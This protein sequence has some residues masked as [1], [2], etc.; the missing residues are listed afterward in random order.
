[1]APS[2]VTRAVRRRIPG[3]VMGVKLASEPVGDGL[4][5]L[6]DL[7]EVARRLEAEGADYI[8]ASNGGHSGEFTTIPPMGSPPAPNAALAANLKRAVRIP[9]TTSHRIRTPEQAERV[10]AD[11]QADLVAMARALIADPEWAAKAQSGQAQEIRHCVGMM[12]CY[13]RTQAATP[14]WCTAN[15]ASG[16]EREYTIR[17][18]RHRKTYAVVGGGPAGLEAARVLATRGHMV[19][20][21]EQGPRLGGKVIFASAIPGREE[22]MEMVDWLERQVTAL[23]VHV[24]LRREFSPASLEHT[25]FDGVVLAV[26]AEYQRPS[27]VF[28]PEAPHL[29][30]EAAVSLTEGVAGQTALVVDREYKGRGPMLAYKLATQGAHV[31][32]L[33]EGQPVAPDED[34]ITRALYVRRA[35]EKGV[36]LLS[37]GR[38]QRFEGKDA[39][40]DHEGWEVRVPNV[41]L[42]A[43]VEKPVA[44]TRL[45]AEIA[46]RHPQLPCHS[47]GDCRAPRESA[48][49]MHDAYYLA[50]RM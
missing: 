13:R 18:A 16:R 20:L 14:I 25:A 7:Q 40:L 32:F 33:S 11:G 36:R 28:T 44:N 26:G 17:R 34:P 12:E 21:F 15:P 48:E 10:L 4:I 6:E 47:I 50:M 30:L 24:H 35:K 22:F 27:T 49:A 2:G 3:R 42:V 43:V 29:N 19:H 9:V 45:A 8:H 23:N 37:F 38:V 46:E 39:V 41:G 5:T 31:V 1:M